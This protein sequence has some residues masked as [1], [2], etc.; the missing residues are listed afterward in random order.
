MARR[1]HR[2]ATRGIARRD[3]LKATAAGAAGVAAGLATVAPAMARSSS[4]LAAAS[5]PL[6]ASV[7]GGLVVAG[8]E[9]ALP[10]GFTYKT[11]G[12]FG[13]PMQDGFATPPIH[14]GMGVFADGSGLRIVRNHE[15]G[16]GNDIARGRARAA[17]RPSCSMTTPTWSRAS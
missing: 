13:S 10:A 16:D 14:D 7:G 9:L 4:G 6:G 15:L 8:P 5:K 17:P 12:A 2:S 1:R 3:F 11:F